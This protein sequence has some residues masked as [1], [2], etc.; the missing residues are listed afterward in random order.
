MDLNTVASYRYART[1]DDLALAP[2]EVILAGGTFLFSDPNPT[3]TGLVDITTMAWP[4]LDRTDDSLVI[5]ATCPIS[6]LANLEPSIGQR[7]HPLFAQCCD[8][9]LASWKVW[10]VATVGGNV[11]RSYSA[12]AMIHLLAALDASAVIWTPDGGERRCAVVDIPTGNGTQ[13]LAPGEVMRC[14]EVPNS[15]LRARTGFRRIALAELGR[16]GAVVSSRLDEDGSYTV[17]ITAA[18]LRAR[19]L[20]YQAIPTAEQLADDVAAFDDFYTDPLGSADWRQG[21]SVEF[22]AR[23][24][25]ELI[26]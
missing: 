1:R 26:A 19:Q 14:F 10:A 24:R 4:D 7:A 17:T 2:G 21:V 13:S 16:S 9:L 18:T 25:E 11:G 12:A 3:V 20:K 15:A 23:I 8:A 6:V 5:S 22:A